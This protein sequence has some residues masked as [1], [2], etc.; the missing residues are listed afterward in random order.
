M[1]QLRNC[2][3]KEQYSPTA[4]GELYKIELDTVTIPHTLE[5]IVALES[6]NG[7]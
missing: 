3:F 6:S 4:I 5:S 2:T 7:I 1:Q